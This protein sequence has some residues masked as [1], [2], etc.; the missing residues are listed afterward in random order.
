MRDHP[1]VDNGTGDVTSSEA[2]NLTGYPDPNRSVG[3]YDASLGGGGTTAD[4]LAAARN[5]DKSNWNNQYNRRV[6]QQLH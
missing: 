2:I 3:S 1:I 6:R 4:F 5:Q